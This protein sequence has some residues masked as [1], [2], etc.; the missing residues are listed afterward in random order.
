MRRPADVASCFVTNRIRILAAVIL[1]VMI[2][3]FVAVPLVRACE[4]DSGLTLFDGEL[5][6]GG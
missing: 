4:A 5:P 6:G 3:G 2:L 1:G